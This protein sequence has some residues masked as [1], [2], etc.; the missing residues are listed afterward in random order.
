MTTSITTRAGKGAELTWDEV[1]ANFTNLQTTAD[2]ALPT[3]GGTLTGPITITPTHTGTLD[4]IKHESSGATGTGGYDW[5]LMYNGGGAWSNGPTGDENYIDDVWTMGIGIGSVV[6]TRADSGKQSLAITMES[7]Y[8]ADS[9]QLS[10]YSEFHIE[11]VDTSDVHHRVFSFAS[12]HDGSFTTSSIECTDFSFTDMDTTQRI[13]FDFASAVETLVTFQVKPLF[14]IDENNVAFFQQRNVADS[15]YLS[16]PYI[17]DGD[18]LYGGTPVC[19]VGSK[20]GA[21]ATYPG[22]FAVFQVG[23]QSNGE[24]IVKIVGGTSVTGTQYAIEATG[25]PTGNFEHAVYNNYNGTGANARIQLRTIGSGGGDPAIWFNING[26]QSWI[27]GIDNSDSDTWKLSAYNGLG[28]NDAIRV[29]TSLNTRF[30]GSL[31]VA[32]ATNGQACEVKTLTELTTIAAAATTDTT[33]QMPANS[34]VLA[35]S[36]RVTTAVTCTSTFTVGDASVA[37][38]FSTAAVSKAANSTD[39]GTKAGA[40]Y[41]ATATSVRITPDTTPS[42]A[43]GRVRVTIHY[44]EVTPPTS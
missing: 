21:G 37:D 4:I 11:T 41:N 14:L 18:V 19:F 9:S 39:K 31:G 3:A 29:D 33:I 30:Y 6:G 25:T 1:D 26:V 43:T 27:C 35:V 36:V 42:D 12:Y 2:A 44:I 13:K 10:P 15:A 16:L 8:Y 7:K 24:Q 20:A 23:A 38:R 28:T 32:N 34:L 22:T 17:D 40:Y 5:K